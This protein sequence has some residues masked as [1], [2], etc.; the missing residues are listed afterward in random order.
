[1]PTD[2][3]DNSALSRFELDLEGGIAVANYRRAGNV[4]TIYH[5]ETPRN[6]RERGSGTR[7][8]RGALD[9]IRARGERV[10]PRCPFVRIFIARHPDYAGL[11][12]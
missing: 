9:I 10:V 5:T 2:V 8:V 12:A 7:L 3:R 6:L 1:M 4:L 11:V